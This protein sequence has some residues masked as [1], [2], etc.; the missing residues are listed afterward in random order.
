MPYWWNSA[1][2]LICLVSGHPI[3]MGSGGKMTS[4]F[5]SRTPYRERNQFKKRFM[6]PALFFLGSSFFFFSTSKVGAFG[7][8]P[9]FTSM[10]I[11]CIF[12][13]YTTLVFNLSKAILYWWLS[14]EYDLCMSAL[15][16]YISSY[17]SLVL[18][19]RVPSISP[20]RTMLWRANNEYSIVFV[21][22]LHTV[23]FGNLCSSQRS[24]QTL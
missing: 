10:H 3:A 7:T 4:G 22:L 24:R 8:L 11:G 15:A 6:M 19:W 17:W 1:D 21:L 20:K 12:F 13:L 9:T 18:F 23:Q 16:T 2:S 5:G 14:E